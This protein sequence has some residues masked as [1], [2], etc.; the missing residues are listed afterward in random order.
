M[1]TIVA[2]YMY[3][4]TI[5]TTD[6]IPERLSGFHITLKLHVHVHTMSGTCIIRGTPLGGD[7][8]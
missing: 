8:C 1:V 7:L 2:V 4:A 3:T 6:G 5:V